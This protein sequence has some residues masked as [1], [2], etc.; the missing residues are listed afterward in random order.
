MDN[1]YY[2][3]EKMLGDAVKQNAQA[4]KDADAVKV[5]VTK[6]HQQVKQVTVDVNIKLQNTV[7]LIEHTANSCFGESSAK[8]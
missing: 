4:T 5:T 1:A 3:F 7:F 6:V 8:W 2:T